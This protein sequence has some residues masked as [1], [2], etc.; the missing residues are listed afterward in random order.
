[1]LA[2][3][4]GNAAGGTDEIRKARPAR[5]AVGQ[6]LDDVTV[7]VQLE[8][9]RIHE[10]NRTGGRFWELLQEE[11]DLGAVEQALLEEF[12]VSR[13][14]LHGEIQ[15]LAARLAEERLITVLERA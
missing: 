15:D 9:S 5:E 8:T 3:M 6:R 4:P 14:Q 2:P 7:V 11:E 1:M 13:E 10:F 12:E